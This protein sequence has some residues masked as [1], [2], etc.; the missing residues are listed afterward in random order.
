MV[1]H[2]LE[3]GSSDRHLQVLRTAGIGRDERQIDFRILQRRQF[4][5]RLLGCFTQT[6]QSHR[7]L[8]EVDAVVLLELGGDVMNQDFVE[9]VTAEVRVAVCAEHF[10]Q[11]VAHF[12]D[13]H[14]ERATAEVEDTN[15]FVFLLFEAVS[16]S[17]SSRLVDDS[18]DFETSD[19]TGVFR[20]L[21]LSVIEISGNS[22]DRLIHLMAKIAFSRLFQFAKDHRR[23]F[24]R[25]VGLPA[26]I[27]FHIVAGT[28]ND[29]VRNELFFGR[30]FVMTA[31]HETLDGVDRVGWI[32]HRL[33]ASRIADQRVSF[34]GEGDDTRS[35]P[36]SFEVGDDLH[37]A[38]F[39]DRDH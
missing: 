33:A 5:L 17:G 16:Q 29:F 23:D 12:E 24:R 15:L 27:H 4:F 39:H 18:R 9:V 36:I 19:L 35:Q 10:D 13:R 34:V 14:V 2:L 28:A 8:A 21:S 6:L 32:R 31:S 30:D 38:T 25:R 11:L 37:F 1:D 22:D 20:R 3:L 26:S 7:V